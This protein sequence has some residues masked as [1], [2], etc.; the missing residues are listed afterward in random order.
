MDDEENLV[1][2][3]FFKLQIFHFKHKIEIN[4]KLKHFR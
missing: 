3:L 2:N 4:F 1:Y